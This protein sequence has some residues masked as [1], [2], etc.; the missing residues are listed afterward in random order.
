MLTSYG[1][2]LHPLLLAENIVVAGVNMKMRKR[3]PEVGE[4]GNDTDRPGGLSA[5]AAD[6]ISPTWRKH[7]REQQAGDGIATESEESID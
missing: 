4:N 1:L 6:I 7:E 3:D 2:V 5:T